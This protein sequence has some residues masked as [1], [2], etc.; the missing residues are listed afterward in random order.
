MRVQWY[1][2]TAFSL[3]AA[4]TTAMVDPCCDEGTLVVVPAVP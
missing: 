1:G 4:P 2:Q 3:R